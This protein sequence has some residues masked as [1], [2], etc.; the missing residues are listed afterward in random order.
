[1]PRAIVILLTMREREKWGFRVNKKHL[2]SAIA[3]I[4]VLFAFGL[5]ANYA[6]RLINTRYIF[7]ING[8]YGLKDRSGKI[9]IKPI[10]DK[11]EKTDYDLIVLEASNKLGLADKNGIFLFP[12]TYDS[13]L[14]EY[15]FEFLD[16]LA[17]VI[18]KTKYG[19][20]NCVYIDKTGKEVLDPTKFNS[21]T[22]QD[23]SYGYCSQFSE[24]LA[25]ATYNWRRYAENGGYTFD[26]GYINKQGKIMVKVDNVDPTM[27]GDALCMTDF[28]HGVAKVAIDGKWKYINKSG[29]FIRHKKDR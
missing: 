10:Y 12:P 26:Y 20:N 5:T 16:G 15:D 6:S 29:R 22:V 28:K 3:I 8:K 23:E 27:C 9:I 21:S 1:M 25:P 7:K 4:L 19:T 18:K 17:A 24:G 13:D 14:L 11:I 2:K